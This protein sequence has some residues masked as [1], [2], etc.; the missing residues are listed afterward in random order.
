LLE[1]EYLGRLTQ[2]HG[3]A[4]SSAS[5]QGAPKQWSTQ[6]QFGSF[7]GF[8]LFGLLLSTICGA[9]SIPEGVEGHTTL[10]DA[11]EELL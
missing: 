10:Y 4:H 7:A 3:S 11:I 8:M 2:G 5:R 6:P 1:K 9:E